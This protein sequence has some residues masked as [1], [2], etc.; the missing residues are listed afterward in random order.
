MN[1]RVW[2]CGLFFSGAL[3][4]LTRNL[5]CEWAWDNIRTNCSGKY[6]ASDK[7]K[8]NARITLRDEKKLLPWLLDNI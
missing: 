6:E 8:G 4:Q 7:H 1:Q 2:K 3:N 5:A